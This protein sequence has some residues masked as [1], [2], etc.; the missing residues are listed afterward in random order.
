MPA[1][2]SIRRWSS[3]WETELEVSSANALTV[4]FKVENKMPE[5]LSGVPAPELP[6][7]VDSSHAQSDP[8]FGVGSWATES[9]EGFYKLRYSIE[10]LPL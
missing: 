6:D 7:I 2:H 10:E 3:N 5:N 8:P 1:S 9:A 4:H